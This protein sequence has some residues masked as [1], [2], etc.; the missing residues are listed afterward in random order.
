[1]KIEVGKT[2]KTRSK[3]LRKVVHE[4]PDGRFLVI[5][6]DCNTTAKLREADGSFS[7]SSAMTAYDLVA[8]YTPPVVEKKYMNIVEKG[9][10][11]GE[12][13]N[14]GFSPKPE[15]WEDDSYWEHR[16]VVEITIT[17]GKV[18]EAKLYESPEGDGK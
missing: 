3:G 14:C 16:A 11:S 12:F 6:P 2:Y 18:T 10:K 8:E 17:D 4:R 9:E 7:V 15:P 1:M 13:S 5:E